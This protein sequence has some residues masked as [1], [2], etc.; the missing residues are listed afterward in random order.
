MDGEEGGEESDRPVMRSGTSGEITAEDNGGIWEE[1]RKRHE[2]V[3][4]C[5]WVCYGKVKPAIM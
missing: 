4:C 3:C 2:S 5:C 1:E